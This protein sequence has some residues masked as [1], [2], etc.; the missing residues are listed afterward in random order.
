MLGT[1][2]FQQDRPEKAKPYLEQLVS[3]QVLAVRNP[4]LDP[5]RGLNW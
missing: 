5:V 4:E 1:Y 3:N 2:H